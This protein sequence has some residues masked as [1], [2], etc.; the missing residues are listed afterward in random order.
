MSVLEFLT[1]GGMANLGGDLSE[2]ERKVVNAVL[3]K[4]NEKLT[5]YARNLQ[6]PASILKIRQSTFL[7]VGKDASE[8]HIVFAEN[9]GG[10]RLIY[11]DLSANGR[12]ELQ[13][14]IHQIRI[15]IGEVNWAF[16]IP[17]K[18]PEKELDEY[19]NQIVNQYLS[20]LLQSQ[21]MSQKKIS[22][23][24]IN[25][26]EI[27]SG[28]EKFRLDFPIGKKTAFIMMLFTETKQHKEILSA[29]KETLHKYDI[30]GLRADDKE[31]MDDLFPNVKVYM[32]CCDF[33]IAIFDRILAD[34]FNPN[35]SL[36]AGY[37]LGMGKKVLFLKD[38]TLKS[39]QTDLVGKL[40]KEFDTVDANNTIPSQI[41]KWLTDK[42]FL[43]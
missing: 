31:Y 7:F 34:E 37:I 35:V 36:E 16:T 9:A 15:D 41:E 33:G 39:L 10:N 19:L 1:S 28:I 42:G 22:D 8:Y 43:K 2:E 3:K 13:S 5:F 21:R 38:K 11:R 12:I 18:I 40:Y 29:V 23:E 20:S 4:F 32:H 17:H 25:L 27:S 24:A 6:V 26:P 14:I 30:N